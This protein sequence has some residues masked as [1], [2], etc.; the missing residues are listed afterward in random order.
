MVINE[1]FILINYVNTYINTKEQITNK[2]NHENDI[3]Y[4]LAIETPDNISEKFKQ[5]HETLTNNNV[6]DHDNQSNR[7]LPVT[8]YNNN[9]KIPSYI[10]I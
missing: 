3:N 5:T 4:Y 7:T 9:N 6:V 8:M 10:C 1:V 2:N